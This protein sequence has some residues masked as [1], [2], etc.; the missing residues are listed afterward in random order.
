MNALPPTLHACEISLVC[1]LDWYDGP[2]S[3]LARWKGEVFWFAMEG[4]AGEEP[5]T[6]QL[7][8][9]TKP[10]LEEAF[11]WFEEKR[12]WSETRAPQIRTLVAQI[13]DATER[14]RLIEEKGLTLRAWH[15]PELTGTPDGRFSDEA[16]ESRWFDREGWRLPE[17]Y[18]RA[19]DLSK[20][21]FL[22]VDKFDLAAGEILQECP[23]DEIAPFL[24]ELV[25]WLADGNWPVSTPI[26]RRLSS[27]GEV[28]APHLLKVLTSQDDC[29]KYFLLSGLMLKC[30]PVVRTL[31]LPDIERIAHTPTSGEQAEKADAAARDV[32]A[33]HRVLGEK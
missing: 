6:Y 32:L 9:L 8:K 2:V 1:W 5:R 18:R 11:A 33:I 24:D 20:A 12:V 31:C 29:A 30:E 19:A 14:G 4:D 16:I 13:E 3:G 15:G 22:P 23:D 7:F 26:I 10:Q 28:L 27:M 21:P 25:S 17:D